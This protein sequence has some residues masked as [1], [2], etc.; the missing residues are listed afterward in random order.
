MKNELKRNIGAKFRDLRRMLGF[1]QAEMV[2]SFNIGRANY[3]RIEKGEIFPNGEILFILKK[4][5]NVCLD[6]LI[7][8]E[9]I[10]QPP[11]KRGM[12]LDLE[13][14]KENS[15]L[16]ELNYL[17]NKIPMIKHAILGYFLEYKAKN[18]ELIQKMLKEAEKE[19]K[20]VVTASGD[21]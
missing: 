20:K 17:M 14:S 16:D 19:E 6:W 2:E 15:E 10:M 9:G 11:R 12:K 4:K 3:S 7:A 21:Q 5:Y 18:K 1:T 8:D 13:F